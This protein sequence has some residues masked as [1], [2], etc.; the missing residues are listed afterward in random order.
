MRQAY[1][2][3]I[4]GVRPIWH[5]YALSRSMETTYFWMGSLGY[6]ALHGKPLHCLLQSG[7]LSNTSVNCNGHQQDGQLRIVLQYWCRLTYFTSRGEVVIWISLSFPAQTRG[8]PALLW[9]LA[10]TSSISLRRS[11]YVAY[12]WLVY[13]R[14]FLIIFIELNFDCRW[15]LFWYDSNCPNRADV[16]AG[17][18]PHP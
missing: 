11:R 6:W 8:T 5:P 7:L 4:R 1:D 16:C 12:D 17:T 3:N 18:T 13:I 10:L 9:F 14:P 15:N 2:M